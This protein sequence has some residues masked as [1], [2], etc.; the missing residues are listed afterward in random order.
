MITVKKVLTDHLSFMSEP[1]VY[2]QTLAQKE[3]QERFDTFQE[4]ISNCSSYLS[5]VV[6]IKIRAH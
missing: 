3:L 5:K 1:M 6:E 2:S 4:I